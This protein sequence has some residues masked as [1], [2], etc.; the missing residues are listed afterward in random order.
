MMLKLAFLLIGPKAFQSRWYSLA[1]VGAFLV[2][3]AI[4]LAAG[5]SRLVDVAAQE[6]FGLVFLVY[7]VLSCAPIASQAIDGATR[8]I[9][10]VKAFGL[11][12]IGGLLMLAP[13]VSEFGLTLLFGL[14]L[15]L[16]SINRTV[17]A[18]VVRYPDWRLMVAVG[19]V[20]AAF[21]VGIAVG[22]PFPPGQSIPLCIALLIGL[23][24]GLLIR[25]SLLLRRLDDEV[26]ILAL[27][28][29][30]KRGWYDNAPVLVDLG[31]EVKAEAP[32]I[33][34]VWTPVGSA[35]NP[36][37]RLLVD[38]YIAAVDANGVISTGH[39]A[40]EMQPNVYISH[41]PAEETERSQGDFFSSLRGTADNDLPGCFQPSYAYEA[42]RWCPADA[43]VEF[44]NYNP[45]RLRAFWIGY[46]QD[47][48]YN[49]TNRNCSVV[50]A[51]A[52]DA[53]LE[54]A[55]ASRF[56]WLRLTRLLLNPDMWVAAMIC[57]QAV[58]MTWTPGMV[59]DY[60]RTM[61]R[62]VETDNELWIRR[63]HGFLTR[64]H[65][66]KTVSDNQVPLT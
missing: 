9:A 49:L 45:R 65:P 26:A 48:T 12:A 46:R 2:G 4:L 60:A 38:R 51:A 22:W 23:W 28:I 18:V 7:G 50:V 11:I 10:A 37:R 47:D 55:L 53:A 3:V 39:S 59:L 29:F 44:R 17:F 13:I 1:V 31:D 63:F 35:V 24:G 64:L 5:Y 54:G 43:H 32:L 30:S 40:L 58:S 56:P 57:N 42:E 52:L 66:R 33:I 41:Y 61:A 21:A 62:L 36:E 19:L 34:H 27:P 20:E 15:L 16:D 25:T 8:S 6:L 14:A